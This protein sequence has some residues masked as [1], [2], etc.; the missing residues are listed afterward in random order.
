[1]CH[2]DAE[3]VMEETC[4][5]MITAVKYVTLLLKATKNNIHLTVWARCKTRC[6]FVDFLK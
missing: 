6:Y 4:R 5:T 3:S 1:M 2:P